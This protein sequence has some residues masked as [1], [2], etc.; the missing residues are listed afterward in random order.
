MNF[1]LLVF[2]LSIPFWLAGA[3]SD[4]QLMT[5]LS[6]SALMAFC[7]RTLVLVHRHGRGSPSTSGASERSAGTSPIV[8]LMAGVNVAVL[9]GRT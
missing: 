1:F 4:M 7:P 5:G 8:V 6:V 3:M 9:G 2:A